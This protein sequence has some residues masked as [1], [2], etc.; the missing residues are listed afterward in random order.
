LS[1]RGFKIA[2]A[3]LAKFRCIGGGPKFVRFGRYVG[4][5]PND[6]LDWAKSRLSDPVNSTSY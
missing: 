1:E 6:L 5:R 4:Y 3:T 2:V